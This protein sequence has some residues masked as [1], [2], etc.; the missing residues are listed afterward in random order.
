M[1]D[2]RTLSRLAAWPLMLALLCALASCA[3]AVE[4]GPRA[5]IDF[6]RDGASGLPGVPMAVV[7]HASAAKGVAEVLFSV[8]G[9]VYGRSP[10]EETGAT[11]GKVTFEW[12]PD[13]PGV[14][15]LQARAYDADDAASSPDTVTV[16]IGDVVPMGP[17]DA[18]AASVTPTPM[19]TATSPPTPTAT[20]TP[21]P[22]ETSPPAPTATVSPT[23]TPT[24]APTA[25]PTALPVVVKFA[26]GDKSLVAGE[27]TLLEWWV[28]NATAVYLN[29]EG[30]AGEGTRSV[31]PA[32]TTTYTLHVEAPA[33]SVD[34]SITVTVSAPPDT[35][36]PPVPVPQVPADGLVLDCRATQILAWLPVT[37][38]SGIAG[39]DVRLEL[40]TKPGVW[41]AD[42]AWDQVAGKQVVANVECGLYYRWHV[43]AKDGAGNYSAWSAWSQF[44]VRLP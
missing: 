44:S 39:Y 20:S 30:V 26:V 43:R 23:P 25:T 4:S 35:T 5:W 18:P 31:C 8:N 42:Q 29:G 32:T 34:E 40:E 9:V 28:Q 7:C 1:G 21:A 3:M 16:R 15:T 10:L 38:P 13:G 37:D 22:T 27:C 17:S 24:L 33:G 11:F 2:R 19:A 14:Y 41:Q 12:R 6:P 36:A